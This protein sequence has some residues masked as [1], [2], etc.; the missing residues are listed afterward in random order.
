MAK[1]QVLQ[2]IISGVVQW[3]NN[4]PFES[5]VKFTLIPPED[6][7]SHYGTGYYMHMEVVGEKGTDRHF[8]VRYLR[9][10]DIHKLAKIVAEEVYGDNM[11]Q[12]NVVK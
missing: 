4:R 8:D 2:A 9:T 10:T 3:D 6:G 12:F 5:R 11:K 7:E 1:E